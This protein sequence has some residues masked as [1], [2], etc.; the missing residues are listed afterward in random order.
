MAVAKKT[1]PAAKPVE[2]AAPA[3]N[4]IIATVQAKAT[5]LQENVRKGVEQGVEQTKVAYAKLKT[6][7]EEAT[8]SIETSYTVAQKGVTEFNTKA[9]D[10]LQANTVA[11][12]DLIKALSG[13]KDI[14]AAIAL[15]TEHARKQYET[16]TAQAKELG[17]IA[18]KVAT[19][20][21][22]PIKST[23]GKT[24]KAN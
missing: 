7:T 4:D 13:V 20:S 10:A 14:S 1:A 8:A 19:E 11:T 15:Q 12:F 2:A 23:L 17:E 24:F 9:I 22:E 5:E 3:A 21:S 16:L 18:K 6:A